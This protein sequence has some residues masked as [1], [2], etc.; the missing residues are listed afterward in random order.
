MSFFQNPFSEEFRGN[1]V[2]S[3][4]KYSPSFVCKGN[5]GRGPELATCKNLATYN[6]AGNDSDANDK[7]VL[8]ITFALDNVQ[9]WI[10]LTI[11]VGGDTD[12]AT[13]PLEIVTALNADTTF[14][15]YFKAGP[16][17]ATSLGFS[18]NLITQTGGD[19]IYIR[20]NFPNTRFKWFINNTGAETVLGFNAK[21]GVVEMPTYFTRHTFDADKVVFPDSVSQLVLLDP[22][23]SNVD[24]SIIDNAVDAAGR[25]LGYD[26]G[27]VRDDWELLEGKSGLFMFSKIDLDGDN[28][29]SIIEYPAGAKAGDLAKKTTYYYT[30]NQ[31]I[32]ITEEPYTL[33]DSDLVTPSGP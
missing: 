1:W 9:N 23:G 31:P 19:T 32:Q 28:I 30:G 20:P 25:P 15:S 2:L 26:S 12:S 7:S 22:S 18:G 11:D 29:N 4:R 17:A 27:T 10:T 33:T 24:A 5:A 21:A 8:T 3:D 13:T 14:A 16:T 6:L